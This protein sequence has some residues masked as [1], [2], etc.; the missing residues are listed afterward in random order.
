MLCPP[1]P[2]LLNL[3][4]FVSTLAY[5]SSGVKCVAAAAR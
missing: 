3:V 2:I 1:H 4:E 5:F